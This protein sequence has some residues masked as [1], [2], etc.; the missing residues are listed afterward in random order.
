MAVRQHLSGRND[1]EIVGLSPD[2]SP[3]PDES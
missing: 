1:I 2:E 3:S